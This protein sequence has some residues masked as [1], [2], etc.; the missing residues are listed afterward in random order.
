[1]ANALVDAATQVAYDLEV[2][3]TSAERGA[4]EQVTSGRCIR[5]ARNQIDDRH[6]FGNAISQH[7]SVATH[8][9][10]ADPRREIGPVLRGGRQTFGGGIRLTGGELSGTQL[11]QDHGQL[12][13]RWRLGQR[14]PQIRRGDIRRPV[15]GGFPRGE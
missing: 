6:D 10:D 1:M 11:A 7:E 4:F 9:D 12:G 13:G 5:V 15:A 2:E 3:L 8:E 14:S